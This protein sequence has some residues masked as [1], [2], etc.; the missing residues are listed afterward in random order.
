[1]MIVNYGEL[2]YKGALYDMI[3]RKSII[4]VLSLVLN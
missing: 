4:I 1:M 3:Q 2:L